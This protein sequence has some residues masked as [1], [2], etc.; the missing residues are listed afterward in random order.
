MS[1]FDRIKETAQH[2]GMT[3][4]QVTEK[5]DLGE[6]T[7]YKWKT[8]NPK[9]E[10]L[11]KVADV[12]GVS[13]DYLLGNTDIPS[14]SRNKYGSSPRDQMAN[15][16]GAMFRSVADHQDLTDEQAKKLQDDFEG[17]LKFRAKW[18]KEHDEK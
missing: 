15:E 11:Q 12:L 10:T 17:Y 16:V 6:K 8:Q 7:I 9:T 13:V 18:F 14:P 4:L 5:S 1:L 3:L 2:Q